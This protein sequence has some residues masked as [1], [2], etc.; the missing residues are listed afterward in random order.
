MRLCH[1]QATTIAS[2][3]RPHTDTLATREHSARACD[4]KAQRSHIE[5]ACDKQAIP[6]LPIQI[7]SILSLVE[8]AAPSPSFNLSPP[9]LCGLLSR[10]PLLRA[11]PVDEEAAEVAETK[12]SEAAA[13]GPS[14]IARDATID[15]LVCRAKASIH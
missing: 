13:N 11:T 3:V 10:L 7:S 5:R 2:E 9:T 14:A 15:T 4:S 12:G 6:H 8:A 1:P